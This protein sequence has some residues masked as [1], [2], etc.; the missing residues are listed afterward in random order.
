MV[1][2][3]AA[4]ILAAAAACSVLAPALRAEPVWVTDQFEIT[5]RTGP[6]NAYAIT[7]MLPSG[8]QLEL[9]EREAAEGY[10]RVTTTGGTE[11]WVLT[12]YLMDEPSAR[13]Q[14][15]RLTR[16]LTSAQSE[17]SSLGTQLAAI[18][19]EYESAKAQI[20]SLQREKQ[21]L[22]AQLAQIRQTAA[23]VLAIDAQNKDLQQKLTDAE[24]RASTLEQE[25]RDLRA[26]T[27][28][29]WFL[30]GGLVMLVGIVLGLWLPRMRVQR[31]SR[32]DRL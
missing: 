14:L 18:T 7:R 25:N 8:T 20:A 12:R 13:E 6:G 27:T 11:G 5:L 32:Y 19:G 9:L 26:Q 23:N 17:G 22:Q 10:S 29:N 2:T 30:A 15:E 31:R 28:R 21:N 3:G 24:I 16:Q 4:R 1:R